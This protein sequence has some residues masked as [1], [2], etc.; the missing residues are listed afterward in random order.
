MPKPPYELADK[1]GQQQ[2]AR[3]MGAIGTNL[4]DKYL[5]A[6]Q[7]NE[8]S[9]FLGQVK[10]AQA[11]FRN[12]LQENPQATPEEMFAER[13]KM[14]KS[15]DDISANNKFLP[16]T[17]NYIKNFIASNKE[18][19]IKDADYDIT[20]IGM[21]QQMTQLNAN[22][23]LLEMEGDYPGVE[24]L[25]DDSPLSQPDK[26]LA[27]AKSKVKIDTLNQKR[28]LQTFESDIFAVAATQGYEE[29]DRQLQDPK[30]MQKLIDLGIER[31]D[32]T[33][34][35]NDIKA[36]LK[37]QKEKEEE[38]ASKQLIDIGDNMTVEDVEKRRDILSDEKYKLFMTAARTT[39]GDSDNTQVANEIDGKIKDF[40]RG[41]GSEADIRSYLIANK[42]NLSKAT[43]TRL[44]NDIPSAYEG[45]ISTVISETR[46]FIDNQVLQRD[47]LG[48]LFGNADEYER[49]FLAKMDYDSMVKNAVESKKEITPAL[50]LDYARVSLAMHPKDKD[51]IQ[52]V[53]PK[54][55]PS[56]LEIERMKQ[57]EQ[58]EQAKERFR[59]IMEE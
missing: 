21:Q 8:E 43:Y 30:T 53:V 4:L 32:L 54:R 51:G 24:K 50:L 16:A 14:V 28:A 7:A 1:S 29:A 47:I 18:K 23:D 34:A 11:G 25:V 49:A 45:H 58:F 12:W 59:A 31:E 26:D 3:T 40:H 17:K 5:Q 46:K 20:A 42:S 9:Q 37:D 57:K 13:D 36:R 6:R 52:N 2:F 19:M 56:P 38:E 44:Q 55:K 22:I 33:A 41:V 10:S 27:K 35:K 48:N 39:Y 15:I